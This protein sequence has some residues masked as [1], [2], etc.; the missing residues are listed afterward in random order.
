MGA[1]L[2]SVGLRSISSFD[3]GGIRLVDCGGLLLKHGVKPSEV[4]GFPAGDGLVA[5][6]ALLEDFNVAEHFFSYRDGDADFV[7]PLILRVQDLE[8]E[9][10]IVVADCSCVFCVH[11]VL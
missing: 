10:G 8:A 5:L 1:S 6:N 9:E 7:Q 4:G 3:D 2:G 11:G